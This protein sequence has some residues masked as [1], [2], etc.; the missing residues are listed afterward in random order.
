[1]AKKKKKGK[2]GALQ[3]HQKR[4]KDIR[5]ANRRVEN[6]KIEAA[7]TAIM[8]LYIMLVYTMYFHYGWKQK[9]LSRVLAQFRRIYEAVISGERSLE[10]FADELRHD[11]GIDIDVKTGFAKILDEV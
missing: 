8:T 2:S 1:M 11:A 4:L 7:Q 3:P 9:R 6:V 10:Q 5:T